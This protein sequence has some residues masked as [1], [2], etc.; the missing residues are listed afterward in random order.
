[1]KHAS[2]NSTDL[3]TGN[4]KMLLRARR[5][6]RPRPN[7]KWGP[8]T[9]AMIRACL[10]AI[11]LVLLPAASCSA[12]VVDLLAPPHVEL[13]THARVLS[14]S[15][16]TTP[17]ST[18]AWTPEQAQAALQRE[19]APGRGKVLN[20]G[21]GRP[22]LWLQLDLHNP[23]DSPLMRQ[24]LIGQSWLDH[25][26]VWVLTA[27]GQVRHW[28]TGDEVAGQPG[29]DDVHGYVFKHAFA[30]GRHRLLVRAQT[31]DQLTVNL[32]LRTT[33][34][35]DAEGR[36]DR[37]LYGFLYGFILS[38]VAYNLMLYV[39]LRRKVY[40]LYALYLLAF[41]LLNLA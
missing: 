31:A 37:Y 17:Q 1:M 6:S 8:L 24:I 13:G 38:L 2:R 10:I 29:L 28:R 19:G 15:E 4:L 25:L 33:E 12:E 36:R 39:G 21:I 9:M 11:L 7:L 14:E 40:V 16:S 18:S 41:L 27:D 3:G 23:T 34:D 22:A 30:P 32:R 35:A 26:D 5:V 20:L